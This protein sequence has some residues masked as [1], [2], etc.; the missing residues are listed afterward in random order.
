MIAMIAA[1]P[2]LSFSPRPFS[3]PL[4]TLCLANL[5]TMP[6]AAAPTATDGEQRRRRQADEHADAAAPAHALAAEVV[7]GLRDADL[8][9]L[10]VLDEDQ[11][12]ALDLLV[13]D[14]LHEPVEV[15]LGRLDGRI[16][17]HDERERVAHGVPP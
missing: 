7:A 4:S 8:A 2:G 13:L 1:V 6:P 14:E 9:A 3:S 11:A 16:R 15:L 12:L 17:G 5:P 10:V